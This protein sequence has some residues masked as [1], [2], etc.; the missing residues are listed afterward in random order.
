MR[1]T[2]W[3]W[4]RILFW[5]LGGFLLAINLIGF[6]SAGVKTRRMERTPASERT[7]AVR[8]APGIEARVLVQGLGNEEPAL[9]I[10]AEGLEGETPIRLFLVDPTGEAR[11]ALLKRKLSVGSDGEVEASVKLPDVAFRKYGGVVARQGRRVVFR[12]NLG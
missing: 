10:T 8:S 1:R 9:K 11:P 7:L 3:R 2:T 5:T 4:W 6:F 12:A